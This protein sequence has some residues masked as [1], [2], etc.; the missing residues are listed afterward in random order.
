[1]ITQKKISKFLIYFLLLI[2][3]IITLIPLIWMVSTSLKSTE[4]VFTFPIQW[5]PEEFN[6][7]NYPAALQTRPF[8]KY[9]L[10]SLIVS[11]SS[12]IITVS[13]S[14]IAGYGFAYFDFPGRDVLFLIV[15][16]TL[17]IPFE[18]IAVPLYV[19]TFAW[20]WVNTYKGLI[21]PTSMSAIGIFIM[22]QFMYSIPRELIESARIDGAS[23]P[24]IFFKI[25]W[26]LTL[27][28]VSSIA[29]FTFVSSWNA[30]L[31][32]LLV[33]SQDDMRTIPLGMALFENQLSVRY[34]HIMA[35]AVFGSIPLL[36][37]FMI[38]QRNFV[39]GIALTGLK[40]G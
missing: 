32:P 12:V 34:S 8:F 22:R 38:F 9:L 3:A 26:R 7:E 6:F 30:Y 18:V 11:T 2:S 19:Q 40:E 24:Q 16:S 14:S 28:A 29:I 4:S 23:E 13:L 39:E 5:I 37:M 20:G 25:I 10:N 36:L 27:P 1:M 35:V 15:L 21:I 17:M 33:V 31:W